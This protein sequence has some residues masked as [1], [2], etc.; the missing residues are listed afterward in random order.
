MAITAVF[1]AGRGLTGLSCRWL[2]AD[3]DLWGVGGRAPGVVHTTVCLYCSVFVLLIINW[4]TRI[5]HISLF[6][7]HGMTRQGFVF[8][9]Q[10]N[11]NQFTSKYTYV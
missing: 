7:L 4:H 2:L 11:K 9:R 10:L 1:A 8:K 3:V 6:E 5:V